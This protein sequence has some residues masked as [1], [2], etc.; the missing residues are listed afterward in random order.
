MATLLA[1]A[2]TCRA[3]GVT[4]TS[5]TGNLFFGSLPNN[6]FDPNNGFVPSGYLNTAGTTVSIASPAVEFGFN[7]GLN[8]DTANFSAFQFTLEDSVESGPADAP[9]YH[10]FH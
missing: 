7:D 5:V 4:G 9:L 3:A 1:V 2:P 8:F 10:V 6:Y